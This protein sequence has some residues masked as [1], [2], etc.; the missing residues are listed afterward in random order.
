MRT[1]L[2]HQT[3]IR[4]KIAHKSGSASA[5][6]ERLVRAGIGDIAACVAGS[7]A[8]RPQR[9]PADNVESEP[10]PY[11]GE[12]VRAYVMSRAQCFGG[13]GVYLSLTSAVCVSIC[14]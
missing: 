10:A 9:V 4:G 13:L 1:P 5:V 11:D 3:T 8:G 14:A 12:N 6:L 7:W 2:C